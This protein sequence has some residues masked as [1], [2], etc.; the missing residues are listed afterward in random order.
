MSVVVSPVAPAPGAEMRYLI[1]SP[2]GAIPRAAPS[3]PGLLAP[4]GPRWQSLP[5]WEPQNL[6]GAP[7]SRAAQGTDRDGSK[8]RRFVG[9]EAVSYPLSFGEAGALGG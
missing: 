9:P 1:A 5:L 2:P 4:R 6:W 3:P 7:C 8:G